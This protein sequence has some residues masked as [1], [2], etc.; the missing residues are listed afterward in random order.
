MEDKGS[1]AAATKPVIH[2]LI[3]SWE[4]QAL[5]EIYDIYLQQQLRETGSEQQVLKEIYDIYLQQ[6]CIQLG[7]KSVA[8]QPL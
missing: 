3:S 5:K 1:S 6:L 2:Q 8:W 4:Q 7:T